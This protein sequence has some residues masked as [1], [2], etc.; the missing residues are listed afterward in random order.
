MCTHPQN[1]NF[2]VQQS[3]LNSHQNHTVSS[4]IQVWLEMV[5]EFD[6]SCNDMYKDKERERSLAT[7][8]LLGH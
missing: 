4:K 2:Q 7:S 1:T 5:G 3:G 8:N 6:L